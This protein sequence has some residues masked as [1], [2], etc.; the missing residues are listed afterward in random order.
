M[1]SFFSQQ[2]SDYHL[3]LEMKFILFFLPIF[4]ARLATNRLDRFCQETSG[5]SK[6]FCNETWN[7]LYVTDQVRIVRTEVLYRGNREP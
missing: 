3:F 1:Y 5:S 2:Y 6:S 7:T 4:G